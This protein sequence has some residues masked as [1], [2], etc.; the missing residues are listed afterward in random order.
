MSLRFFDT[1]N[2]LYRYMLDASLRESDLLADL[3][4][5]TQAMDGS[6]MQSA[7]EA[8][9]FLHVLARIVGARRAI[10]VGLYTGYSSLCLAT[11]LPDD[12]YLLACD[13]DAT[14]AA[15]AQRYWQRAGVDDR[16]DLRLGPALD[17]LD[18][19]IDDG[20]GESYDFIFLDADKEN[21]AAYYD[22]AYALLR[23]GGLLVVDNVLWAGRVADPDEQD[24]ETRGIRRLNDRIRDDDRI[25]HS[26][27]PIADGMS[28]VF[29]P[30]AG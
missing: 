20:Q 22:R 9:Q 12:G 23:H 5:E 2:D 8:G 21:Y 30:D 19:L 25:L 24:S 1:S 27:V 15:V 6:I 16:V 13:V 11:A 29:K 28:L 4:E 3:R 7:P 17:T 14:A 26:L 10:E 18:A